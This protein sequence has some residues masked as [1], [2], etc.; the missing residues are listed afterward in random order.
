MPSNPEIVIEPHRLRLDGSNARGL[1][2]GYDIVADGSDRLSTRLAVHDACMELRK[3]LVS[4]SGPGLRW[5]AATLQILSRSAAS[6][7][8]VHL[9]RQRG[10]GGG[11]PSCAQAGVLGPIAGVMGSLQAAELVKELLGLERFSLSGTLLLYDG[12]AASIE[13]ISVGRSSTCARCD[14]SSNRTG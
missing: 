5:S 4:A 6:L 9:V 8:S 2:A 14:R 11:R 7:P 3:P 10:S 13:R 1:L 12:L